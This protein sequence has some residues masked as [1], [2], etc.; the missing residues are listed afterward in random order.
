MSYLS[1]SKLPQ[2]PHKK[3]PLNNANIFHCHNKLLNQQHTCL[4]INQ[5][6]ISKYH[7]QHFYRPSY[8]RQHRGGN[9]ILMSYSGYNFPRSKF[10]S[11]HPPIM[12]TFLPLWGNART[13]NPHKSQNSSTNK[14]CIFT[15]ST[16]LG[17][18]WKR[19]D[20]WIKKNNIPDRYSGV[21]S[22]AARC[23]V[24]EAAKIRK[25]KFKFKFQ[26]SLPGVVLPFFARLNH[27]T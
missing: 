2:N 13:H 5:P 18:R 25:Q 11:P 1:I 16:S 9:L 22:F 10:L 4:W 12:F 8:L 17:G 7:K 21:S 24:R 15:E 23:K 3:S 14:R 20:T 19:M 26:L 27:P 6:R